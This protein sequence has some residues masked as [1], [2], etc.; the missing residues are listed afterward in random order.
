MLTYEDEDLV[1][2][3]HYKQFYRVFNNSKR[4]AW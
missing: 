4:T 1:K 3:S 2:K